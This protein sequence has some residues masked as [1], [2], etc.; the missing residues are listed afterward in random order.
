VPQRR[1]DEPLRVG[2][3]G[4][5]RVAQAIGRALQSCG[6][7]IDFIASRNS[8]HAGT[9]ADFIGG[10]AVAVSYHALASQATH[11]LIA[12]SDDAIGSVAKTLAAEDGVMR[13]A[14]HTSGSYGPELLAPL[15][16][17]GISCGSM[18]PLQTISDGPQGA[19]AL[20]NIAFSVSGSPAA[21]A[22]AEQM[23]AALGGQVLYIRADSRHL[24]HAA[25]VMASNY[26]ATLIDAAQELMELAGISDEAA[27]RALAPLVRT[28][29]E[30]CLSDGPINALTG[31]VVR[32]DAATVAAH[33]TA[34][35]RADC[36]THNLYKAAGLRTLR[37]ACQ[38]GLGDKKSEAMRKA[39][40]GE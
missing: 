20:R 22:W 12:V 7:P 2:I 3:A 30:N 25:A 5:G 38:R 39:L 37:M 15:S 11:V 8:E 9:A 40:A 23:I 33:M 14:L 24:Y 10:D 17:K 1:T 26:V 32:G 35:K 31:P 18:H 29:V 27:L 19:I 21:A 4:G 34:L 13:M 16:E 6:V 28:S 36:S